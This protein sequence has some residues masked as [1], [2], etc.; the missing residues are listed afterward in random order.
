MLV[1]C[2]CCKCQDV[3]EFTASVARISNNRQ[4]GTCITYL[5]PQFQMSPGNPYRGTIGSYGANASNKSPSTLA[6]YYLRHSSSGCWIIQIC[7][8]TWMINCSGHWY[9]PEDHT[10]LSICLRGAASLA[11]CYTYRGC[12]IRLA[13]LLWCTKA[14][15]P[16]PLAVPEALYTLWTVHPK[17]FSP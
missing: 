13:Y 7:A 4:L 12:N 9:R 1:G 10:L 15:T 2:S 17:C 8:F 3:A 14:S 6:L 11:P 16:E 5:L